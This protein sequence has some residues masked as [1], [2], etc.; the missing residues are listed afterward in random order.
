MTDKQFFLASIVDEAAHLMELANQSSLTQW[1]IITLMGKVSSRAVQETLDVCINDFPKVKCTL[2]KNYPSL[3]RWF[4]YCWEYQDIKGKDILQEIEDSNPVH[5]P[6]KVV[7]YC[8]QN[9][10]LPHLDITRH[11]PL[12]VLLIRHADRTTLVFISHHAAVDGLGG[13]LSIKNFIRVY[14]DIFYHKKKGGDSHPDFEAISKPEVKFRSDHFSPRHFYF[15]LKHASLILR[16]PAVRIHAQGGEGIEGK[17][18]AVAR[19]IAP[20]QLK[21]I[22]ILA[23]DQ[24]A[25]LNDY[26]LAAMFQTIRKWNQQWD[27]E[28]GRIYINVPVS[29]RS[30]SDPIMGNFISGFNI[31]FRPELIGEKGKLLKLIKKERLSLMKNN[32][33]SEALS[34]AALLKPLPLKLKVLLSKR[35]P[36]THHPT[37]TLSNLG[38]ASPNLSHRD[39]EGFHYMGS[40]RICCILPINFVAPWPQVD[41]LIY[42]NSMVITLSLFRSQFSLGAAERFLDYFIRELT[43]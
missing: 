16:E 29:L 5:D 17:L 13:F 26:L 2:V 20:K 12:K 30:R 11:G 6:Q 14:E 28:S 41:V 24:Q 43:E 35:S 36:H 10:F 39:K 40:A 15:F 18:L 27:E 4:R 34:M 22:R 1:G 8:Q 37:L 9:N 3:K 31:S 21:V 7:S 42:H 19:E 23:K 32:V 38:T 25:S 33:A